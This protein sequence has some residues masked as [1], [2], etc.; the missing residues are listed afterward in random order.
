MT[1]LAGKVIWITGASSGIGE[2][3]AKAAVVRGAR[4]ILTARRREELD[5]VRLQCRDPDRAAVLPADLTDFNAVELAG[6]AAQC[7]GPIDVLVNNAGWSQ[8]SR[9]AETDLKVY[10]QLMELDFFAPLALTQA[11]LP[12]MRVQARGGH[13]VMIGS[14]LSRVATPLRSGYAA[15]KHA[16]AGFTEAA[17]A[18]L[19]RDQVRFTLV[20]PGY[21]S[22]QVSRNALAADGSAHG[23][24]DRHSERGLPPDVCAERIWQ[25]VERNR[26]E[27]GVGREAWAIL[28]KRLFPSLVSSILKHYK[29]D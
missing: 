12:A 4:V 14:V 27:I 11:V 17:S 1:E 3:L 26:A 24:M 15:A 18:E 9:F 28:L 20:L 21:V 23:R 10:R 2:A 6:R 19:W 5:R 25:A 7:F 22:T 29:P 13:V 16:L 8:R